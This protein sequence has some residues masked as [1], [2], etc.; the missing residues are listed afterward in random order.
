[1]PRTAPLLL[2]L[3]CGLS[4]EAPAARDWSHLFNPKGKLFGCIFDDGGGALGDARIVLDS[5]S[6]RKPI[7]TRSQRCKFR[8][9]YI[10]TGSY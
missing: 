2:L 5:P 7:T 6:L 9:F 3:L 8:F 1:M 10:D 4:P